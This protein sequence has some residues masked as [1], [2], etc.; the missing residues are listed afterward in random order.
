MEDSSFVKG[1]G[2]RTHFYDDRGDN[3]AVLGKRST[4]DERRPHERHPDELF[5]P[6]AP[7]DDERRKAQTWGRYTYPLALIYYTPDLGGVVGAGGFQITH[8]WRKQ[9]YRYRWQVFG[10]FSTIG[11]GKLATSVH[12]PE[13]TARMSST[14]RAHY[15][16]IE[17]LRFFGIGND[18]DPSV[19]FPAVDL[20]SS[21][22]KTRHNEL[23][24]S[25]SLSVDL[26]QNASVE[27]APAI[28]YVEVRSEEDEFLAQRSFVGSND[29]LTLISGNALVTID[30]RDNPGAAASG[31]FLE[32]GGKVVPRVLGADTDS[33]LESWY[34]K[35]FGSAS[36]HYSPRTTRNPMFAIRI[37]GERTLGD[38][39]NVPFYE[40]A[41]IGGPKNVRGF[42]ENRFAGESSLYG[43]AEVRVKLT[44]FRLIFPW[45]LGVHGL[46]DAG[47]VWFDDGEDSSSIHTA[48]GGGLWLGILN[49]RQTVSLSVASSDEETLVYAKA[50]F[51]F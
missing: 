17:F 13:I 34:G 23:Y 29:D 46:A 15:S 26:G 42:R 51:H 30:T 2:G 32:A 48:F 35:V 10:Q 24:F 47:R 37:G 6:P 7:Q 5:L 45:E 40:A 12:F 39:E 16:G 38:F 31:F 3:I 4:L 50:G 41:F 8:G 20:G 1:R 9:P 36:A 11:R 49:R 14:L 19:D 25:P 44:R 28:Q 33:G 27:F 22:Y 18:S 21:F 43:N